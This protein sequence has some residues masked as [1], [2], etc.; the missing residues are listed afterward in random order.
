MDSFSLGILIVGFISAFLTIAVYIPQLIKTWKTKDTFGI[1]LLMYIIL[2]IC[3]WLWVIYGILTLVKLGTG[4]DGLTAALPILITNATL[5][6][7]GMFMLFLK[8]RNLVRAKKLN[9]T[10]REYVDKYFINKE[11]NSNQ[12]K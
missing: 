3:A 2:Q 12:G 10:E 4:F 1:S 7:I 8:I 5:A 9:M 6:F 11:K